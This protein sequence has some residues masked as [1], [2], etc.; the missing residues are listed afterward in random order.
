[1]EGVRPKELRE[2]WAKFREIDADHGL[3]RDHKDALKRRVL[4]LYDAESHPSTGYRAQNLDLS[5][6]SSSELKR[7]QRKNPLEWESYVQLSRLGYEQR[8]LHEQGSASANI[9]I[10]L[11]LDGEW[12]YWDMKTIEGGLSSLRKRMSECYSK[13]VRLFGRVATLPAGIDPG[14]LDNP[15]VVVDNRY[16]KI[17]DA[18]AERQIGESIAYLSDTGQFVFREALLILKDGT[19]QLIK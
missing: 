9:D 1:M 11:F 18:D 15:R 13:W 19:A 2:Q 5:A 14:D 6:L 8:L 12:H 10:S 16:S 7:M 17:T 4:N 3:D